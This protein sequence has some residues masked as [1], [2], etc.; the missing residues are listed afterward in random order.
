MGWIKD[1][2]RG[3]V[4]FADHTT[5]VAATPHSLSVSGDCHTSERGLIDLLVSWLP[6]VQYHSLAAVAPYTSEDTF[7]LS[8]ALTVIIPVVILTWLSGADRLG[9]E[10]AFVLALL[11]PLGYAVVELI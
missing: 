9:A 8:L 11:F 4:D 10:R 6:S 2:S 7:V 3:T 5:I 1:G